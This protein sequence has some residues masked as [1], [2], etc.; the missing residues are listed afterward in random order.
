M[1]KLLGNDSKVILASFAFWSI[2][3][4]SGVCYWGFFIPLLFAGLVVPLATSYFLEGPFLLR[5]FLAVAPG[6]IASIPLLFGDPESWAS[7]VTQ[8]IVYEAAALLIALLPVAIYRHRSNNSFKPKPL[9][10]S[11]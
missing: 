2:F 7:T 6:V 11:A 3:I 9:R 1:R 8:L 5:P 4:Y 10:G